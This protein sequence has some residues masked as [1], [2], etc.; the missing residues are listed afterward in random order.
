[1]DVETRQNIFKPF[2]SSKGREGTGMG[3]YI[4]NRII[5]QHGGEIRL[6]SAPGQGSSFTIRMPKTLPESVRTNRKDPLTGISKY[7]P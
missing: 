3:L 6:K 2:F 4:S 5:G 7:S 1:M